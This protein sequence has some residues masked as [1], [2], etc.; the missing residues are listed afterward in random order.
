MQLNKEKYSVYSLILANLVT[1]VLAVVLS[2]EFSVVVWIYW[3]QSVII[4][5]FQVKKILDLKSFSVKGFK[6]AGGIAEENNYTKIRSAVFFLLHYG[7]F[8]FVYFLFL[9]RELKV[10]SFYLILIPVGVFFV[11]H[12]FS[13]RQNRDEEAKKRKNIG[14]MMFV[15]Y[16]RIIP[17]HL[18][19][20]FG[21]A[22]VGGAI[23]LTIF[24]ILKTVS[25]VIMHLVEHKQKAKI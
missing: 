12:L 6:I 2:W 24:L 23:S 11:N 10:E 21:F 3:F 1:I 19:I 16:L 13:Y 4:G 8:H 18:I 17:M 25:D 20:V 9:G 14:T 15:P 7:F 22:F 5:L